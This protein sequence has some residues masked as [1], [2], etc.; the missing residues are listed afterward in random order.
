MILEDSDEDDDMEEFRK[1]YGLGELPTPVKTNDEEVD[2]ESLPDYSH[3]LRSNT[4]TLRQ[5][6]N[7][8]DLDSLESSKSNEANDE[9]DKSMDSV[10][11]LW[12]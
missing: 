10:D 12:N 4:N 11:K 1:K 3:L 9:L 8:E 2:R 5:K 7:K 6:L